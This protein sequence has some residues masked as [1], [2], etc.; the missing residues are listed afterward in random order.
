MSVYNKT[1]NSKPLGIL[2]GIGLLLMLPGHARADHNETSYGSAEI[3]LGFPNGQVTVGKT[4][5]NHPREV[6]VEEV[7]HRY[8]Q[9][10]QEEWDRESREQDRD[11]DRNY[12]D[13]EEDQIIIKKRG[14]HKRHK[15]VVIIERYQEPAYCEKR[16][17][18]R[19][20][21]VNPPCRRPEVVVYR[22]PERIIYSSPRSSCAPSQSVII[23]P[24][25][26]GSHGSHNNGASANHGQGSIKNH[27]NHGSG[28]RNLFPENSERPMRT[29]GVQ[30]QVAVA[31][32]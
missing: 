2:A 21:Y 25:G 4:W 24:S 30:H 31:G 10:D 12:D 14:H 23:V 17:V 7:T 16:E 8:P 3:T 29:R 1:L 6:V 20:V 18:V 26:Q 11:R 9:D 28:K 15:K 13:D 22:Q 19:R 32:R 27:E 5:E